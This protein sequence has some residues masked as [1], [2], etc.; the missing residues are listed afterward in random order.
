M[1]TKLLTLAAM[2]ITLVSFSQKKSRGDRFF[3]NGDYINAIEQ[4][5]DQ[6]NKGEYS[7]HVL[8]NISTSYY[9]T[10]QFRRAY[11]SMI[12][13]TSGKFTDKDKTYDNEFNF[14]MYQ[15][16]SAL[17]EYDKA[18]PYLE[19][20]KTNN[21]EEITDRSVAMATIEAFKLKDDDFTIKPKKSL[22]STASEFGAVKNGDFLY[23]TSDRKSD[24][25]LDKNYRWTHRPF[26]NL[27]KV[28]VDSSNV[29]KSEITPFSDNINSNLHEGNFCITADGNTM[30]MS[31]SN[32]DKGRKKFDSIRKNAIHLYKSVKLDTVWSAPEKLI[33]NNINYTIEHPALNANE[34]KLY[35]TS[36]MPGGYGDFDLY[37][38]DVNADGTYGAPVNLGDTINTENREQFPYVSSE[39]N[40]FFSS[41]GHLGLGM[42]DIFVAKFENNRYLAP[43][44]L[45][46][47]INSS[48]DDF[49][50]NYY[51][52]EDGFFASN[53]NKKSDEIYSFTQVGEV[54]LRP[55]NARFEVREFS[56]KNFIPNASVTLLDTED[57]IVFENTLDSISA[58]NMDV[59]PARYNLKASSPSHDKNTKP[60]QIKEKDDQTYV[61][62]LHKNEQKIQNSK[63][64][65]ANS[66]IVVAKP[67]NKQEL[68][69]QLLDDTEGPKVVERNGKM[70][71]D[72]PPIYFDYDKWNIR[73]DSKKVLNDFALKLEKYKTVY[74]KIGAHTD[75]RGSNNY[76]QVLSEKR[77]ESTRNYLALIGFVNA[78]RMEYTGY[79]ESIPLIGCEDKVCSEEE[80]QINRRSEFE[81]VKY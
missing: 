42:M 68:K 38:V 67:S 30:Y 72:L 31:R 70:F 46:A 23:F 62:Y 10:F 53:R 6:L 19:L 7:K 11:R 77:A 1:K 4:Y 16:L 14:K 50:L 12:R 21:K 54:F 52:E 44:N 27:Y 75:S 13:V 36:N 81:I 64:E 43:V 35:F 32:M 34:D 66:S 28:Q 78:R 69:K 65:Y 73:E 33:F 57:N 79:G 61:I 45:G 37:Y 58:F 2:L 41:N 49:S 17:G 80:H 18:L 39:G 29:V 60:L 71:F 40:L 59:M 47:P 63:D 15:V 24:G 20:Y 3:E 22:N 76:N 55:Y 8:T 74:I 5:A 56:T 48:Y 26:L 9:N 51:N 25:I